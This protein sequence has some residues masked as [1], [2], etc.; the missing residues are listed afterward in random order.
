MK[1]TSRARRPVEEYDGGPDG[2]KEHQQQGHN[3]A[4]RVK[5]PVKAASQPAHEFGAGGVGE[6]TEPEQPT[7]RGR[8]CL[9]RKV[10]QTPTE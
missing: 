2:M 4:G 9:L 8:S 7:Y 5:T 6:E 3:A 1:V 10:A